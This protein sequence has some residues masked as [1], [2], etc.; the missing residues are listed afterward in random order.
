MISTGKCV[1]LYEIPCPL[2]L[3]SVFRHVICHLLATMVG[4]PPSGHKK[5]VIKAINA[6]ETALEALRR[7]A[8]LPK[9]E[10]KSLNS[11]AKMYEMQHTTLSRLSKHG[12]Q[13]I[14]SLNPEK[15]RFRYSHQGSTMTHGFRY[16]IHVINGIELSFFPNSLTHSP[17]VWTPIL[18]FTNFV[19]Q[20]NGQQL[21]R[22][23]KMVCC[24]LDSNLHIMTITGV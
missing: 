2:E 9:E 10:R 1:L 17:L 11:I 18:T 8:L 12:A 4:R 6:R 7:N 21:N 23:Q 3:P 13:S 14:Q 24:I 22:L 19:S 16:Y 15:G 5:R 20:S